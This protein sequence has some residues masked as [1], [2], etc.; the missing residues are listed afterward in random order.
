MVTEIRTRIQ[1]RAH[2]PSRAFGRS[3]R[4]GTCLGKHIT[5]LL[6]VLVLFLA[7]GALAQNVLNS[8]KL[9]QRRPAQKQERA[10]P[11]GTLLQQAQEAID[12]KDYPA[13]VASLQGYLAQR[14]NDSLAHFQ[15]GYAYTGL[16]RWDDA[17]SEYGKAVALDPKLAQAHLNLGLVLLDR[18]PAAAVEPFRHTAELQPDQARPLFLLGLAYE[19]SGNIANAIEQYQ[20]AQ[21]LEPKSF[22][23]RFALGRALLRAGRAPEAETQFHEAVELQKDSAPARLGLADSLQAQKKLEPAVDA[24]ADYL[25]LQPQ[26]RET[27]RQ[28]ASIL[29]DL[30]RYEQ[31]LAEL[32][33]SDASGQPSLESYKLRAEIY[34]RQSKWT[35]AADTLQKALQ[36]AP[37]DAELHA[38]LGKVWLEKR[39]SAAAE[40][41]LRRALQIDAN[42]TEA[43]R[44]LVAVYYLSEHY[45]AA[46]EVMDLLAKRDT[47]T[48]G[49]WFVRATCYDKL[50]RKAEAVAAYEKF[51]ALDQGHNETHEF[52]AR[53]RVRLLTRELHQKKR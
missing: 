13:A 42:W 27:R 12:K 5:I 38:R 44:D 17:K 31:G 4:D 26:D 6:P 18:D 19:K 43:L 28:R 37:A 11:L 20:A 23:I 52:Q 25:R 16:Q 1:V 45:Q 7:H 49:S 8:G 22:D 51:L 32:D 30:G 47:P 29:I 3:W 50:D 10:D 2:A 33:G 46:L 35:E 24:F 40:R 14:P 21:R 41:E 36:V 39:D 53:Q 48:A 9:P 15:L 34:L